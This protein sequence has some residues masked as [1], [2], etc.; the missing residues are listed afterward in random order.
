[1]PHRRSC[2]SLPY[3]QVGVKMSRSDD[4]T[5]R[6]TFFRR[7]AFR[8]RF[9]WTQKSGRVDFFSGLGDGAWLLY[10]ICRSVKA[11]GIG[12]AGGKSACYIGMAL[13]ENRWV[14]FTLS[15]RIN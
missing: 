6:S 11:V 1:M 13:K 10:G 14:G 12:S 2:G 5:G 4:V 8:L 7:L 3:K 9:H 15:T